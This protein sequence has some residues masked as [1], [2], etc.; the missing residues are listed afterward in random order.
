MAEQQ[1]LRDRGRI[2]MVIDFAVAGYRRR[3]Q[4]R[5]DLCNRRAIGLKNQARRQSGAYGRWLRRLRYR[6]VRRA[7][8]A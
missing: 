6:A 5:V 2:E 4:A 8:C 1:N 3:L 7:P